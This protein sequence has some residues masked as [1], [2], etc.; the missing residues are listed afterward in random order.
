MVTSVWLCRN[1]IWIIFLLIHIRTF[2][3]ILPKP[4]SSLPC[5][6]QDILVWMGRVLEHIHF[7]RTLGC[8]GGVGDS[9]VVRWNVYK[10]INMPDGQTDPTSLAC[11]TLVG[12]EWP[13]LAT[14]VPRSRA[15]PHTDCTIPL[16][17]G[18]WVTE[19][20]GIK[21]PGTAVES[22]V[23]I[24]G[25]GRWRPWSYWRRAAIIS[26]LRQKPLFREGA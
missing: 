15:P 19:N 14:R 26:H 13:C 8:H 24:E 4:V 20:R 12:P 16:P 23:G 18:G 11:L 25:G 7:K 9:E 10:R 1:N 2:L 17:M 22:L 6:F 5:L 3:S 21:P